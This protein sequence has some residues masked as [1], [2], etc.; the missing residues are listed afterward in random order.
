VKTEASRRAAEEFFRQCPPPDAEWYKSEV[1]IP[2]LTTVI[3]AAIARAVA[4]KDEESVKRFVAIG[5][6]PGLSPEENIAEMK[7]RAVEEAL[8]D[9]AETFGGQLAHAAIKAEQDIARAVEGERERIKHS[10]RYIMDDPEGYYMIP[11]AALRAPG[12]KA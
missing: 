10:G 3:D 12:E 11:A 4:E 7:A 6:H 9:A 2:I 5:F 8:G 1:L